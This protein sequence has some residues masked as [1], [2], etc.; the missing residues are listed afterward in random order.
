MKIGR[1]RRERGLSQHPHC[2]RLQCKLKYQVPANLHGRNPITTTGHRK[3]LI[4]LCTQKGTC[5]WTWS[6]ESAGTA[7]NGWISS[8]CLFLRP[9]SRQYTQHLGADVS[10]APSLSYGFPSRHHWPSL[11]CAFMCGTAEIV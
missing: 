1:W 5:S 6:R 2:E 3:H 11:H 10:I 7:H 8:R 9:L 4:C